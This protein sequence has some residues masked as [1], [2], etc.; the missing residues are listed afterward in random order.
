MG[1]LEGRSKNH[2][3][4]AMFRILSGGLAI[5]IGVPNLHVVL[6]FSKQNIPSI[7]LVCSFTVCL[8][9]T[10]TE[11]ALFGVVDLGPFVDRIH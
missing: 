5:E 10:S 11:L 4:A 2:S 7:G 6:Y 3:Y 1:L 8:L 9:S